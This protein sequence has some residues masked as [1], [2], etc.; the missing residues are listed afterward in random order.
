MYERLSLTM[1]VEYRRLYHANGK[2]YDLFHTMIALEGM[3]D[4]DE[5]GPRLSPDR[6][7]AVNY[8]VD[9]ISE[10]QL[11]HDGG[12][13]FILPSCRIPCNHY[14]VPEWLSFFGVEA[15]WEHFDNEDSGEEE[16]E[17]DSPVAVAELI[18]II[19][20]PAIPM[21]ENDILAPTIE[22]DGEPL[23]YGEYIITEIDDAVLPEAV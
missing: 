11:S 3:L 20:I 16:I 22:L 17:P 19:D 23:L 14:C 7:Q 15:R 13:D 5:D 1:P 4:H 12:S 9:R 10:L 18:D 6:R 8:C 21:G 2:V